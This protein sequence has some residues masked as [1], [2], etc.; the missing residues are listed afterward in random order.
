LLEV[1]VAIAILALSLTAIFSSEAGAVK[2]A[3]RARRIG[4][5]SLLVRCKMGEIEEDVANKGLPAVFASGSDNCCKE[6]EIDGYSCDWEMEPVLLPDNMFINQ[7]L[8]QNAQAGAN[9]KA[10]T[11]SGGGLLGSNSPIA[12]ALGMAPAAAAAGAQQ[13]PADPLAAVKNL[14]P[15]QLLSGGGV[16]GIAAMALS[17]VFPILKPSFEA[18]IRRAT[19][20]VRW[21]EGAVAHTFDVTQYIVADQPLMP[22]IDPVTGQPLPGATPA[23]SGAPGQMP[24]GLPGAAPGAPGFGIA[25]PG[26]R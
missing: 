8:G 23:A 9:A 7:A 18:Q 5:A 1:M 15:T 4:M 19:V 2:M 16:G 17:Y 21:K 22:G 24:P 11:S 26:M 12:A 25:P 20:T 10:G 6:S 13:P 14:D 3:A